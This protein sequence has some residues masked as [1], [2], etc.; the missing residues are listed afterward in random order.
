M[1]AI[2]DQLAI[3][4][5]SE[6]LLKQLTIWLSALSVFVLSLGGAAL[7]MTYVN[8]VR[9]RVDE[10][11]EKPSKR[12]KNDWLIKAAAAIGPIG[13][14]V[15]P[16]DELERHK[17]M[18]KLHQAGFRTA[19]AMQAFYLIKTGLI[20]VAPLMVIVASSWM[21]EA[22]SSNVLLYAVMAAGVGLLAPNI[23][24]EKLLEKRS[25]AIS[26]GFPDALDLLVVCVESGLGLASALQRVADELSVS[27]P[28]LAHELATVNSE[29][30]VGVQ[31]EQALKNLAERTG[32]EDIRG[33][34]GL[35]VQTMRF[36]T[37]V[38]DALRVYSEEFRDKRTQKAEEQAAKMGTKLVFP[39][40]LCMFPMFFI[41][42]IGPAVIR[43]IDAFSRI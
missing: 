40:V 37:G 35:L 17:M 14:F 4:S 15:L 34:V 39:L 28:E 6:V 32:L 1:Q 18:T 36:G 25:R 2:I 19:T 13:A 3:A 7:A 43:I 8:P 22:T 30:R 10:L 41:V 38:A 12:R 11:A 26:N 23:F 33:L 21:P 29:I 42:A 24:L 5:G 31:R 16:Q 9:R 27:H 20:L